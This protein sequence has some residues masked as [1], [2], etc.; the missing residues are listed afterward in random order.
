[1]NKRGRESEQMC[2]TWVIFN[3]TLSNLITSN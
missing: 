1:M 2:K 3:Q